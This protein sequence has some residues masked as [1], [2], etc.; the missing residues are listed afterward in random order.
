MAAAFGLCVAGVLVQAV[1]AA[2][3]PEKKLLSEGQVSYPPRL[4]GGETIVT[5]TSPD[6]LKAPETLKP[7]VAIAKTPPTVDFMYYPGQD[8]PGQ[9]W[10]NWGDSLAA[11]GKYYSAIGDHLAIGAKGDGTHG[12]GRAYVYEYDPATRTMRTLADTT[13]VLALPPGQ[14]TPGKI[15]SRL[16][17]GGD[18]Q[19][20][21]ATH[22]GSEKSAS[23]RNHY[24]GDWIIRADPATGK[25]QVVVQGPV[26]KHS[27]PNSV[28][29]GQRM[30]FYGGTAAGPDAA[31]KGI[32]FFAYDI[33]N[34][35]LL[36][37]GPDG[38][39]RYMLFAKSTGRVYFVPDNK[40]G[41]LMRYDPATG[42]PPVK[43]V[44]A[45]M[46]I[47]AATQETAQGFIYAVSSGQ[48]ASDASIWSFNTRTEEVRKLGMAAIGAEAYIASID[49]DPTGRYLYYTPG[50]HGSGPRDNTP[51]V[52]FDVKTSQKKVIAFLHPFYEKKYGG[53]LRGTYATAMDPAGPGDKLYV[54]WNVSRNTKAWDCCAMTVIHIPESERRP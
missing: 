35:K 25:T 44:G 3:E 37:S 14:Y 48:G 32:Q 50:A 38:P 51:I 17:V 42:G 34:R 53:A 24:A 16:D 22:R 9:P 46:G 18:G 29:D 6:F 8:Y 10:S 13:K 1:G 21:F 52:Q 54:T 33:R 40:E 47:R 15:H 43:V 49:V 20:Y 27:T 2:Q 45:T 4:P 31:D 11:N 28:L 26:P 23:D 19:I 5:D 7:G 30:I 36:Y 41:Q 39:A 12:V